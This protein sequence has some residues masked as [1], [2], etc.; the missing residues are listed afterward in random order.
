M[1]PSLEHFDRILFW[2]GR[3]VS[4]LSRKDLLEVIVFLHEEIKRMRAENDMDTR[5]R[6]LLFKAKP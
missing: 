6:A 3:P 1:T 5:V 2:D 4:E